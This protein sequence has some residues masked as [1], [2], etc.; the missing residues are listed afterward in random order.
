VRGR[1]SI[2]LDVGPSTR[3][4]SWSPG[5]YGVSVMRVF[6]GSKVRS[7]TALIED[8]FQVTDLWAQARL[9]N[10]SLLW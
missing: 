9:V 2:N 8:I 6:H 1:L 10:R 7:S 3:F 5:A 4:L